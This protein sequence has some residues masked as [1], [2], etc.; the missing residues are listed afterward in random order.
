MAEDTDYLNLLRQME[1]E[2]RPSSDEVWRRLEPA[3]FQK[4][5]TDA[6]G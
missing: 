3:E 2:S 5:S 6:A 4:G 1:A